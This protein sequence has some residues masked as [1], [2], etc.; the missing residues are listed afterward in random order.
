MLQH[1]HTH[2]LKL[3][4]IVVEPALEHRLTGEIRGLGA[5]GFSIVDG[6]GAG[7]R[8]GSRGID[9]PGSNVRIE[10]LVPAPVAARIVDHLAHHYFAVA[11]LVAYVADVSVVRTEKYDASAAAPPAYG[12]SHAHR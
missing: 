8:G 2:P 1:V 5:T 12:D 7:T 10:T 11:S 4:T 3:V 9:V 6:H